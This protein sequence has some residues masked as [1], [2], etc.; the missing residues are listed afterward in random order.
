MVGAKRAV[1]LDPW[2]HILEERRKKDLDRWDE[3]WEGVLHMVPP[4]AFDHVIVLGAERSKLVAD[5]WVNGGPNL[6]VEIWSPN[7]DTYAK[8]PFYAGL[9]V[10]EVLVIDR[11]PRN[12]ELF[13]L[14]DHAYHIASQDPKGWLYF[15]TFPIAIRLTPE[16]SVEVQDRNS[17]SLDVHALAL[18]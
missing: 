10:D 12:P 3:V 4:P 9:G 8:L 1:W 11:E 16:R 17:P 7:D 15:R 18:D 13:H 5:G 2:P 6:V 14:V